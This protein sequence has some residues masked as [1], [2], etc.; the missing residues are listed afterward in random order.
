MA[1]AEMTIYGLGRDDDVSRVK[2]GCTDNDVL[3]RVR[4]LQVGCPP[5]AE[6]IA[7]LP[8]TTK[9]KEPTQGAFRSAPPAR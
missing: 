2:I 9:H 6:V 5:Q 7:A 1:G 3:K 4:Q 8:G